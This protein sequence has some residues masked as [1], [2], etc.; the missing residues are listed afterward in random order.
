MADFG[1]DFILK[2]GDLVFSPNSDIFTTRD[3]ERNNAATT[4]FDG[5]YNIIFSVYN[6]L[7]TVVGEIPF[8]PDYGTK[9]PLLVSK[10]NTKAT[11]DMV[12]QEFYKV[13]E[14]DPRISAIDS[15]KVEQYGNQMNVKAELVLI[16]KSES[17]VFIFPNFFIE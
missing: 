7:N 13:L 8:H 16:G 9:L 17:S 14:Q 12:K 1:N 15:I 4:K 6:R 10:P 5:Y 3:Y 11:A 2:D